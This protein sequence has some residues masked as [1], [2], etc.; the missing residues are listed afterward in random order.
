[1][2]IMLFKTLEDADWYVDIPCQGDNMPDS[3]IETKH[4][5]LNDLWEE[6]KGAEFVD[7]INELCG[8][9]FD[10]G[11]IDYF[12]LDNCK[13]LKTWLEIRLTK[14][15]SELQSEFYHDLLD[16]VTRAIEYKTGVVLEF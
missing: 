2:K 14:P 12:D 9:L 11:D 5:S 13:K 8:T 4:Y 6:I 15:V 7:P 3:A 16:Y 1:M 10:Y